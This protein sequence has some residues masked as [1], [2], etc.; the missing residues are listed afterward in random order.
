[1][2]SSAHSLRSQCFSVRHVSK[3]SGIGRPAQTQIADG[4]S[5]KY[6]YEEFQAALGSARIIQLILVIG[7]RITEGVAAALS[8]D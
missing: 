3:E 8:A 6:D 7:E 4:L 1:M 5:L 2:F